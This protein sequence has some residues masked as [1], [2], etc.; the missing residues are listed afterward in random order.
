M[1]NATLAHMAIASEGKDTAAHKDISRSGKGALTPGA[2]TSTG[3]D[4]LAHEAIASS[5]R[6]LSNRLG[7]LL[8]IIAASHPDYEI[9]VTGHSLGAGTACLLAI[10]LK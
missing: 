7:P 6:N 5:A 1:D 8:K 3:N 9:T 10:L 4:T 2:N